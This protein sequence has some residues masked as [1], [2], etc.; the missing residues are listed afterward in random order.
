MPCICAPTAAAVAP[1]RVCCVE[2]C[3]LPLQPLQRSRAAP[4]CGCRAY[5][6]ARGRPKPSRTRDT[7]TLKMLLCYKLYNCVPTTQG[8]GMGPWQ[9]VRL[10]GRHEGEGEHVC[11]G[12]APPNR[13]PPDVSICTSSAAHVYSQL[14]V[15]V[16]VDKLVM[17][18]MMSRAPVT[19]R[20]HESPQP[21]Q[22]RNIATRGRILPSTHKA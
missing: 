15:Y 3:A 10:V 22:A 12:V 16:S 5:H 21:P 1:A 19:A 9:A 18:M 7:R 14:T 6:G 8:A 4:R 20:P 17:V 11:C 13:L 2:L